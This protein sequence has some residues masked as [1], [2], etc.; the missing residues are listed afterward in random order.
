MI[1]DTKL[2]IP[3]VYGKERD[4]QVFNKLLDIILTGCKYDIDN[5][6]DLYDGMKCPVQL[7]PLLA[8]TLNYEYNFTDTVTSNRRIIDAFAIME[9]NRGSEIGLKM[10]V[11]LSLTSLDISKNKNELE[12]SDDY[13]DALRHIDIKYNYE[14]GEIII[15]YPSIYTLVRYIVDYVR[16]VG[17]S[18][19]LRAVTGADINTDTML[20]YAD[21]E[22]D[23]RPY[24]PEVDSYV[25]RSFV[26]LSGIADPKWIEDI[27]DEN[28]VI[29]LNGGE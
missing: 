26:N 10:A 14:K 27:S 4:M 16:P 12:T 7:L 5:L 6:G 17:M 21:I 2:M 11:A 1:F 23:T 3:Q 22:N 24:I 20:I 9:K 19:Y 13:M 18:L 15:D 29:D 8:A 25:N 28:N